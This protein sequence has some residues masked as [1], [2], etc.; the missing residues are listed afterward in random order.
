M[1]L[2]PS[3]AGAPA[4][5]GKAGAPARPGI[6]EMLRLCARKG[7]I[8]IL[9]QDN[10]DPDGLASA[11]ALRELLR[12]R[13]KKRA[14]IGYGGIAGRAENRAMIEILHI[15]ARR[16]TETQ[17]AR[18]A[19]ICLV[20]SQPH[21]GNNLLCQGRT[22]DIVFDHHLLPRRRTWTAAFADIRPNYGATTTILYEY[23]KTAGVE[24][25]TDLATAMFYG[26]QSDT[27]DLG[28]EAG[29]AD[30]RAYQDLF[31]LADKKKLAR[32]RCAPV[33]ADYF[34]MLMESLSDCLIAGTTVV[35]R[36]R[37][38][39]DVDAIAEVADRML[40]LEGMRTSVCYAA[41]RDTIYISARALDARGN[42]ARRIKRVVEK[43][44]AGGGHATMAGGQV[45]LEGNVD[46]RLDLVRDRIFSVF[47]PGKSPVPLLNPDSAR[48]KKVR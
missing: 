17:L 19:T 5:P 4:R 42:V 25:T 29:P 3:K 39:Q 6:E 43:L 22:A 10:P 40:R 26:I 8:V 16:L 20:D 48:S 2:C 37:A 15:G 32:I 47:A 45:P 31:L 11:A 38:C 18:Y 41:C 12:V 23:L 9:T 24:I 27:Q 28:R 14:A 46:K 7:R 13:L 44:G 36:I 1:Q 35:S 30:I 33:S 21:A 34:R